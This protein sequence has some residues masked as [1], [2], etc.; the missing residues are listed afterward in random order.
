MQEY[1]LAL[2]TVNTFR[3]FV[4]RE[5]AIHETHKITNRNFANLLTKLI[6]ADKPAKIV[7]LKTELAETPNVADRKW[8]IE[9]IEKQLIAH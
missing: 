8:L 5:N 6:Q 4:H 3:V 7:K 9:K 2:S 1:E